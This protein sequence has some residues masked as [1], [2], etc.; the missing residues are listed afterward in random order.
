MPPSSMS[1]C[2]VMQTCRPKV[3]NT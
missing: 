2:K 1:A 3:S